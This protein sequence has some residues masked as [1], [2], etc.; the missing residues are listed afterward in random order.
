M[1]QDD[2]RKCKRCLLKDIAPEE[3]LD[4][5]RIYLS[6]LSEDKKADE[7]LYQERLSD[8][9]TCDSLNDGVC[10]ICGCFVEYRAAIK[11]NYCPSLHP[12]WR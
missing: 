5:M 9:E 11:E 8:C 4:H 10:K 1:N 6:G 3:Y 12:R 7:K 2:L